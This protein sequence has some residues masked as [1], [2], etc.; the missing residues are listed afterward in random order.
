MS[1][2]A[3][4]TVISVWSIAVVTPGPNFFI[5]AQTSARHSRPAGLAVVL[6]TCTGTVIWSLAGYF[7]IA[8]LFMIAPWIYVTLKLAGGG[9]LIYLGIRLLLVSGDPGT[10]GGVSGDP[11]QS[12]LISW[13]KGLVTNL[14]NPK[15]AMFIT[16]LFA[17]VLPKEPTVLGG[18][19]TV[20]LMTAIS[21]IWYSMVVLVFASP[22]FSRAYNRLRSRIEKLAGLIFISFGTKLVFDTK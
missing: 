7:G 21:L 18:I 9:Y 22:L 20:A 5:T 6:G 19:L 15:T 1:S 10:P 17:S 2:L 14:S 11:P 4:Y 16:S 13:R 3:L 12:F 8:S